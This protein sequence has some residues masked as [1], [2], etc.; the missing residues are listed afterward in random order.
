MSQ[1]KPIILIPNPEYT[2]KQRDEAILACVEIILEHRRE[3]LAREALQ[4]EQAGN[5]DKQLE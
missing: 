5:G 1:R 4:R 3:R 2:K